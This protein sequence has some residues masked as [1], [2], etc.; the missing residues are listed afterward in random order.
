MATDDHWRIDHTGM[1]VSNS[2]HRV[3][4]VFELVIT[5]GFP[6]LITPAVCGEPAPGSERD[7]KATPATAVPATSATITI[8]R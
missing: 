8:L 4:E 1:G 3:T 2:G 5:V 6:A 7:D